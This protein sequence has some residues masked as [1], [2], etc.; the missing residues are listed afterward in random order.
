MIFALASLFKKNISIFN[1][2]VGIT[3]T[4]FISAI[5]QLG[6]DRFLVLEDLDSLFVNRSPTDT[7]NVSFNALSNVLD[8]ACRKNGLVT[9]ITCNHINNLDPALLRPGRIDYMMKFEFAAKNQIKEMYNKF[10]PNQPHKFYENV[11]GKKIN[12]SLI[13]KF[14][15]EH[16]KD[17]NITQFEDELTDLIIQHQEKEKVGYM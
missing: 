14:L 10:L 1:F 13:Q 8:G 3:D 5:S 16:R 4:V 2:S 6:H 15:F 12:M 11:K 17:F 9:F 7:N